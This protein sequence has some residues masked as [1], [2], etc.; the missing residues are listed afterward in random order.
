MDDPRSG[1]SRPLEGD[2]SELPLQLLA[3]D[4]LADRERRLA[5]F[6]A[7]AFGEPAW[8]ILL[9]LYALNA[10][11]LPKALGLSTEAT[12]RWIR[13]LESEGLVSRVPGLAPLQMTPE[14]RHSMDLYLTTSLRRT[15]GQWTDAPL[16]KPFGITLSLM[17][18][19]ALLAATALVSI[20]LTYE[21]VS[22][23][24]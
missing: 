9:S 19:V 3:K 10:P 21:L 4:I 5:H 1:E 15:K 20:A 17:T 7:R 6:P 8:E 16:Q 13:F 12:S 11:V 18:L 14:A 23:Q 22:A 2:V 24:T